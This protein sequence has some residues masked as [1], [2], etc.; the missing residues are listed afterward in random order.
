MIK[1]LGT[2]VNSLPRLRIIII[3][4]ISNWRPTW[5]I[6]SLPKWRTGRKFKSNYFETVLNQ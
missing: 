4:I 6:N 3:N 1:T 2:I 5:G